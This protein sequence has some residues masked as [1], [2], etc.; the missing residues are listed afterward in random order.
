MA[1]GQLRRLIETSPPRRRPVAQAEATALCL[2][3]APG[4]PRRPPARRPTRANFRTGH[5]TMCTL[6]PMRSFPTGSSA[7]SAS[8]TGPF[9]GGP[10]PTATTFSVLIP[11]SATPIRGA[12]TASCS[13][14]PSWRPRST[15]VIIYSGRDERTNAPMPPAVP[16]GELLD[17]VDATVRTPRAVPA[18]GRIITEHPLQPFDQRN[19]VAGALTAGGPWSFDRSA[20]DGA[21]AGR[22][23]RGLGSRRFRRPCLRSTST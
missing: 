20:L 1:A 9:P 4:G 5:L 12:R 14:T 15:L 7:S 16:V 22:R 2:S 3:R 23:P 21:V 8:T 6:V 11:G 13:S 10:N 17:L 18:R 19:F